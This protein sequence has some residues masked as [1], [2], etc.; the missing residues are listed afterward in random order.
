MKSSWRSRG[1][2]SRG[3]DE[4]VAHWD[5]A[6]EPVERRSGA[7]HCQLPPAEDDHHISQ[8]GKRR[9]LVGGL[10][11]QSL[12]GSSCR[13]VGFHGPG[14]CSV[15]SVGSVGSV[16]RAHLPQCHTVCLSV[17]SPNDRTTK[18][19]S[20]CEPRVLDR[21]LRLAC[22]SSTEIHSPERATNIAQIQG[23][24]SS[25]RAAPQE[26]CVASWVLE[27]LTG[28]RCRPEG[29]RADGKLQS[30]SAFFAKAPNPVLAPHRS[31][32]E[33]RG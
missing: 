25:M 23:Q 5:S 3:E 15:G 32:R 13:D 18:V 26:L 19:S 7:Q 29:K 9:P 1:R 4:Q 17:F 10:A 12:L 24:L 27:L 14:A 31:S 22:F 30:S 2:E 8:A 28:C 33:G 11:M 20:V 6:R 21:L 16:A